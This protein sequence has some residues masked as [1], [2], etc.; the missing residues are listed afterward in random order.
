MFCSV[1]KTLSDCVE[2]E[3][4]TST[5]AQKLFIPNCDA[6]NNIMKTTCHA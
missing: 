6:T 5:Q 3:F 2:P 1:L 4:C